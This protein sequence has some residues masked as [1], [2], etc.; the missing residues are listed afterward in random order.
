MVDPFRARERTRAERRPAT[1]SGLPVANEIRVWLRKI[2]LALGKMAG[3]GATPR[4]K[5]AKQRLPDFATRDLVNAPMSRSQLFE[6]L[7]AIEQLG[8][9]GI[10]QVMIRNL[11]RETGAA[12]GNCRHSGNQRVDCRSGGVGNDRPSIPQCL[13]EGSGRIINLNG[14]LFQSIMHPGDLMAAHQRMKSSDDGTVGQ[15]TQLRAGVEQ[16]VIDVL[17]PQRRISGYLSNDDN[18]P[19]RSSI[20]QDVGHSE[21]LCQKIPTPV[22]ELRERETSLI[23][24]TSEPNAVVTEWIWPI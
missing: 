24:E 4:G 12:H 15:T 6:P 20:G 3:F 7:A 23:R 18:V 14:E 21:S 22:T 13:G 9:N 2:Q 1:R 5:S 11:P 10:F 19:P 16:P 17:A 8:I